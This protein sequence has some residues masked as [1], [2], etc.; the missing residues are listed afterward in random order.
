MQALTKSATLRQGATPARIPGAPVTVVTISHTLAAKLA[1]SRSTGVHERGHAGAC[2][3]ASSTPAF[4]HTMGQRGQ[5]PRMYPLSF[6]LEHSAGVQGVICVTTGTVQ[7]PVEYRRTY[8]ITSVASFGM[9]RKQFDCSLYSPPDMPARSPGC[10][11]KKYE[12]GR[13]LRVCVCVG[14]EEHTR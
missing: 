1:P 9:L 7:V 12:T 10:S 2:S 8:R 13:L 14:G 11:P 6:P 3:P 4:D 5:L